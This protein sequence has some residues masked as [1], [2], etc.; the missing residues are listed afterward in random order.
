MKAQ[1]QEVKKLS[2][3]EA[4]TFAKQNNV[5][6]RNAKLD[7]LVAQKSVNELLANG[8]PQANGELSYNRNID[9][10]V[11]PLPDFIT[12]A[13][14][15][16]NKAYFNLDPTRQYVPGQP[17]PVA[18]GQKNSA[19]A[20][21]TIGQLLFDGTFFLGVKA[22][23]EYVKLSTLTKRKTEIDVESDVTKAYYLVLLNEERLAQVNKNIVFMEKSLSDLR[24]TYKA[25]LV[26]KID[27][28]RLELSYSNAKIS[29]DQIKDLTA[30]TYQMLKMNIGSPIT[31]SIVLTDKLNDLSG[32]GS[33]NLE[34]ATNDYS[35]RIE[36]QMTEQGLKL[37]KLDRKR[38]LTGYMPTITAFASLGRNTFGAEFSDL[39][40]TWFPST[41]VGGKISIP[42]FDGFRKH[43]QTQKASINIKKTEN[44]KKNLENAIDIE[45][46]NAKASYLRTK[47]QVLTQKQNMDLA[48]QIFKRAQL[49]LKEGVG[50]KH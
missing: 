11:T 47:E 5:S 28:D 17:L 3:Q 23:K 40:K 44:L 46:F 49:K 22:A 21:L 43:A 19:T 15:G 2:L 45:R 1:N 12:P 20:S 42:I 25:G 31:D 7:E 30:V 16:A 37:N 9:I 34:I 10:P 13:I 38:Y 36:Y 41:I 33:I 14:I 39:G 8:L 6:F 26:E 4:I 35:K 50:I 24:E 48:E 27:L 32:Q 18:F 29:R